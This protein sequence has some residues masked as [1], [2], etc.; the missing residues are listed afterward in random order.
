MVVIDTDVL[1]EISRGNK[2]IIEKL[3]RLQVVEQIAITVFNYEEFLFGLYHKGKQEEILLG[4]QWLQRIKCYDYTQKEI[5][6]TIKLRLKLQKTGKK[7]GPYDEC[8]A[9]ICLAKNEP[10]FTLNKK[11]FE[12]AEGL[13][14]I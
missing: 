5:E 12:K 9:G 1:I 6:E 8:I 13:R 4:K 14:I 7:I 10:L 2:G 11:H 3:S